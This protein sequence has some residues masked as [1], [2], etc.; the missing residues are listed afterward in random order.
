MT[1][2]RFEALV[3][4]EVRA[5]LEMWAT[6]GLTVERHPDEDAW[7]MYLRDPRTN[8]RAV[9]VCQPFHGENLVRANARR[10]VEALLAAVTSPG[11]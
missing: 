6:D 1:P 8:Y 3:R 7:L 10:A 11:A 4:E 5:P 2:E 9:V